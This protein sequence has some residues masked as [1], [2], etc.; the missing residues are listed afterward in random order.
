MYELRLGM[1]TNAAANWVLKHRLAHWHKAYERRK[2]VL[3]VMRGALGKLVTRQ[4][5]AAF[6]A[7]VEMREIHRE[8]M[9]KLRV[10]VGREQLALI[11]PIAVDSTVADLSAEVVRRLTKSGAPN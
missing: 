8:R 3:G 5:R 11:V 7:W 6:A 4:E 1:A 2:Y 9:A 10:A